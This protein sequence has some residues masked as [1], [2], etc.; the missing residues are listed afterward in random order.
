MISRSYLSKLTGITALFLAQ[1]SKQQQ[2][3]EHLPR[4]IDE[5]LAP[6]AANASRHVRESLD[7]TTLIN[8]LGSFC[9][10]FPRL[11]FYS[12]LKRVKDS[13]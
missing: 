12:L 3:H 9:I 5:A 10:P 4:I 2:H 7:N 1:D 11:R 8:V 6:C 13:P